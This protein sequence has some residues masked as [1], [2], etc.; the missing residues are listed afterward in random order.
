MNYFS[1]NA[2][3]DELT[4]PDGQYIVSADFR[5]G[6][7]RRALTDCTRIDSFPVSATLLSLF[8]ITIVLFALWGP[9]SIRM[10]IFD[11]LDLS[12]RMVHIAVSLVQYTAIRVLYMLGLTGT[13]RWLSVEWLVV[14]LRTAQCYISRLAKFA[15]TDLSYPDLMMVFE[16]CSALSSGGIMGY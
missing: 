16:T 4:S 9:N 15:H 2:F 10:A 12:G 13:S 6:Y 3:I 8:F 11:F 7:T 5:V 1:V 14:V